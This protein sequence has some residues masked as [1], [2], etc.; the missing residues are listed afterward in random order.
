MSP[1][2]KHKRGEEGEAGV[3]AETPVKGRGRWAWGA[4]VMAWPERQRSEDGQYHRARSLTPP[5]NARTD[6]PVTQAEAGL[7]TGL[8]HVRKEPCL[9]SRLI[10]LPA[11]LRNHETAPGLPTAVPDAVMWGFPDN[12]AH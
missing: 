2:L 6:A 3:K 7:C 12:L 10:T 1:E 8:G 5:G 4:Q 11:E 9:P